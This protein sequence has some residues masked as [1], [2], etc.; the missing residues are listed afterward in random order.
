[1]KWLSLRQCFKALLEEHSQTLLV[2]DC[3]RFAAPRAEPEVLYRMTVCGKRPLPGK[4]LKTVN[5][6][7]AIIEIGRAFRM[8]A[9]QIHYLYVAPFLMVSDT[10]LIRKVRFGRRTVKLFKFMLRIGSYGPV[11][12]DFGPEAM[13][14]LRVR[15]PSAIMIFRS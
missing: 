11:G 2:F 4:L 1:M 5:T 3:E 6:S 8:G 13:L 7:L 12:I 14:A 9:F 10:H 15:S